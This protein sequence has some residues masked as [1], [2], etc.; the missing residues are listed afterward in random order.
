MSRRKS[1][2]ADCQTV[3]KRW[4]VLFI[5]VA[6]S[7]LVAMSTQTEPADY[8]CPSF[9]GHGIKTGRSFCDVLT[10]REPAGGIIVTIPPERGETTLTFELSNRHTYSEDQ[11]RAGRAFA[12]YTATIGIL[13]LDN[14]LLARAVVQSEFRDADDLAD[15][16]DGGAGPGGVKAVAPVGLE[17]VSVTIPPEVT[18]VSILG[19]VLEVIRID[20]QDT[21][22]SPGRPIAIIS[23]VQ[24]GRP[25]G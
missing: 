23:N 25:V 9:L 24:I 16:D 22:R 20:G 12:R 3:T 8:A 18:E 6:A 4:T 14:T 2:R 13:T 11:I 1:E 17:S 7:S 15:R 21:F 19:E 10:G 5:T